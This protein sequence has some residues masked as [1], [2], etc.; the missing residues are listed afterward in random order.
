ME[1]VTELLMLQLSSG[2]RGGEEGKNGR[3]RDSPYENLEAGGCGTFRSR[4]RPL[5]PEWDRGTVNS[6]SH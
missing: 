3:I 4:E 2:G 1:G 5:W 6:S